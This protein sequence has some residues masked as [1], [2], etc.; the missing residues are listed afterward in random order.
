MRHPRPLVVGL[1][2]LAILAAPLLGGCITDQGML[3][4][5]ADRPVNLDLRHVDTDRIEVVHDV[6]GRDLRVTSILL[7][8]T[9][10]GPR[11]ERAVDD[12]LVR[13]DGDLMV[14]THVHSMDFWFLIGISSLTVEG[15]VVRLNAAENTP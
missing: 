3:Q 6:V 13:G 15:D 4:M 1:A 9:F 12:A 2:A 14:R 7:I 10:D 5:V 8:P 11:L